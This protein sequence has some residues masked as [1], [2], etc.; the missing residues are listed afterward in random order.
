MAT[1][2]IGVDLAWQSDKNHSGI[3]VLQGDSQGVTLVDYSTGIA[4]LQ[5][6]VAYILAHAT[7][8]T[9]I[10]ID[11]PLVIKNV[12]GQ[13]PCENLISR[14]FG[15]YHASAHTSNLTR[16][17]NAGSVYL[18]H[19]LEQHGFS[20]DPNPVKDK[21]RA[22]RWFFEVYPHPAQVVLFNL[23]K[24]IKYKKGRLA[25]KRAGLQSLRQYI[26]LKFSGGRPSLQPNQQLQSLLDQNL[27]ALT[28]KALK[29]YEDTLDAL[30]CAYLAFF[31]WTWGEEKSEL[32][33]DL[34][35]GYI[36]NPIVAL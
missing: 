28:G 22:G 17:P 31:Y 24:I 4:T 29:Q 11:A 16:Y 10:A 33:G 27:E 21:Q 20:H 6:V 3:V 14:R 34:E 19:L 25:H 15:R 1:I 18:V 7:T 2:F 26:A 32:I 36:I 35:T 8:D 30:V 23:E 13:R 9:V 12:T 5:E